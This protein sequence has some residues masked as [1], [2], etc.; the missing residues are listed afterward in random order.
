M[1][2]TFCDYNDLPAP[3]LAVDR[4]NVPTFSDYKGKIYCL[5]EHAGKQCLISIYRGGFQVGWQKNVSSYNYTM[6][7]KKKPPPPPPPTGDRWGLDQ[8]HHD[9]IPLPLG[10]RGGT[11]GAVQLRQLQLFA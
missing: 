1:H 5:S 3:A 8:S 10:I 2:P 7:K 11:T 6:Q 9:L 4:L